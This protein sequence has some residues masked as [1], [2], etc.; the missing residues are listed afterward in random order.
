M[1]RVT[2]EDCNKYM[3]NRFELILVAAQRGKELNHGVVS[4]L[5]DVRKDKEA[6]T[7]L[8]EIAGGLLNIESIENS[9][10]KKT[11]VNDPSVTP[12]HT[13]DQTSPCVNEEILD[14]AELLKESFA[15]QDNDLFKNEENIQE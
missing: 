8:R 2:V 6:I 1:S 9:I 11:F 10:I 4:S 7:A 3:P 12:L 14:E 5:K 15:S 13:T